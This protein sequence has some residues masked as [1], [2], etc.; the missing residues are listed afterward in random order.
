[1]LVTAMTIIVTLPRKSPVRA[2][3]TG[4]GLH[5]RSAA[6]GS[7]QFAWSGRAYSTTWTMGRERGSTST[8]RPFTTV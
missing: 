3:E 5:V 6:A 4:R 1:M 8:V 7:G 2:G